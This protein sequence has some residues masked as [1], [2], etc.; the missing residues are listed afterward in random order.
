MAEF[1]VTFHMVFALE[2]GVRW[3]CVETSFAKNKYSNS[4]GDR[5]Q[6]AESAGCV[7]V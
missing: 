1:T 3:R 7:P 4:R 5:W 2:A 6:S